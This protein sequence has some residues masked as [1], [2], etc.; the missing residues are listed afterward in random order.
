MA[1]EV[2][3]VRVPLLKVIVILVATLCA[4]SAKVTRPLTAVRLVVPWSV[5]LPELRVAVTTLVLFAVRRLPAASSILITGCCANA[6]PAVAVD[7]G[8]VWITRRAG[9]PNSSNRPKLVLL[10]VTAGM[11]DVPVL[12]MLPLARGVAALGRRRM[13][14]QVSEQ[15]TPPLLA[16]VTV[17]VICVVV[18]DVTAT[19][20]PLATPLMFLLSWPPPSIRSTLT[21]GAVPLVSKTNPAGAFRMIVPVPTSAVRYS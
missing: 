4:K 10:L 21:V 15:V 17:K 20:A 18:R 3:L 9:G 11:T 14:C 5:P 16:A 6:T 2:V 1:V 12:V 19:D 7:E 13:F 8:C